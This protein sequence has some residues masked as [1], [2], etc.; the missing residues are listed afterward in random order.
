MFIANLQLNLDKDERTEKSAAILS[1]I[2]GETLRQGDTFCHW[3]PNEFLLL[4]PVPDEK[5]VEAIIKRITE[6]YA[7]QCHAK[8]QPLDSWYQSLHLVK[9]L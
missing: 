5:R 1:D 4:L 9:E 3:K 8:D 2:L 6:L 7:R